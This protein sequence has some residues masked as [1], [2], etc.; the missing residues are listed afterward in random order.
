MSTRPAAACGNFENN[1][2]E[3]RAA[4]GLRDTAAVQTQ[5]PEAGRTRGDRDTVETGNG[6]GCTNCSLAQKLLFVFIS[7][8]QGSQEVE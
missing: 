6:I 3:R 7:P 5:P 4:A 1:R 2:I 8:E